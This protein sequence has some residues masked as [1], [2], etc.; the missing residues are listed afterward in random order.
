MSSSYNIMSSSHALCKKVC[1]SAFVTLI[2]DP[3]LRRPAL[4]FLKHVFFETTSDHNCGDICFTSRGL[5]ILGIRFVFQNQYKC[6]NALKGC[7]LEAP[8]NFQNHIIIIILI[9]TVRHHLPDT[10]FEKHTQ[11]LSISKRTCHDCIYAILIS[12][13]L[14]ECSI[15]SSMYVPNIYVSECTNV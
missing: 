13:I 2:L 3:H 14:D 6:T 7:G 9:L 8:D 11:L 4:D 1:I 12:Y 15:I 5:F 10:I